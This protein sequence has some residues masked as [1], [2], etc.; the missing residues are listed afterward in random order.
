[1]GQA[2]IPELAELTIE[3]DG[4]AH[5][6]EL[7][8]TG[9]GAEKAWVALQESAIALSVSEDAETVLPALLAAEGSTPPPFMSMGLDGERYYELIGD[10]MRASD[11]EEMSAEMRAAVSDVLDV[12]AD[13]YER[14]Q[15]DVTFTARG[16]EIDSD[17]TLAD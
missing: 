12:A 11:D 9:S 3:P 8:D 17:V 5:Q 7:P 2:M 10:A 4:K 16:V 15:V 14:L 13:F 1:M 6:F